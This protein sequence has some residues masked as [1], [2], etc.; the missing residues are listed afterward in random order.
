MQKGHGRFEGIASDA[1][2]LLDLTR[3]AAERDMDVEVDVVVPI[4]EA[5]K[6][7]FRLSAN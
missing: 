1:P 7:S 6:P 4:R 3:E 5:L 2:P